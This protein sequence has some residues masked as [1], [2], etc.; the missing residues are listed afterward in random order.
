MLKE[1]KNIFNRCLGFLGDLRVSCLAKKH[2]VIFE[3][4]PLPELFHR[5]VKTRK[6]NINL[7]NKNAG[8]V[9]GALLKKWGLWGKER[10]QYSGKIFLEVI[11]KL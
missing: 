6:I 10:A 7:R 3:K 2:T 11:I 8:S 9:E 5:M 4:G 1:E